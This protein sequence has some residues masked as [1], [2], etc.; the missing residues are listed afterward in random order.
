M[1]TISDIEILRKIGFENPWWVDAPTVSPFYKAMHPRAYLDNI[2]G[3]IK[4]RS[5]NRA[6]VLMGPRRV[7]KTV[8]LHHAIQKLLEQGISSRKICYVSIDAPIYTGCSLE[9]L[10][11]LCKSMFDGQTLEGGYVF[12]DEIQYLKDWEIHLKKLVDDYKNVKFIVSGSAAAALRLKSIESGAG[13]FTNFY[14]PPLTFYEYLQLLGKQNLVLVPD[15]KTLEDFDVP[16]DINALNKEFVNYLNYG[17]YPEAIFSEAIKG[18]P[19]R[20]IKS[21]IIDKVLLKD[22]PGLYGIHDIQ[23]L[24]RLFTMLALN[25][26]FELS[27]D[28]LSVGSG[29]AK[30][31]IKRYLEYLEAA[32][33]ITVL[34]RIDQSGKQFKRANFFK[35]YL[36]NPSMRC[37]LFG[38]I[39][40]DDESMGHMTET[41][42]ISQWLHSSGFEHLYY[43][44]WKGGEVDLIFKQ[45]KA[46]LWCTEIK[47]SNRF[48]ERPQDL[49]NLTKFTAKHSLS[50]ALVTTID[51][52]GVQI[53]NGI[54]LHFIEASIYSYTVGRNTISGRNLIREDRL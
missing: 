30:N 20:Y 33:L 17:G 24:N 11:E 49:H 43:A 3:L 18:D 22:I 5:V 51:K 27:L 8:L 38:P 1:K 32:F 53:S 29:V 54:A 34:H 52:R 9:H 13:R 26:G 48:F 39:A 12:F 14:L 15:T 44:R 16:A 6:L 25:S 47:W 19:Q 42:I 2:L 45:E 50:R 28:K 7:G 35:V 23:E 41:A 21:D 31:T 10:L 37:A 46:P 4:E 36:A 40:V